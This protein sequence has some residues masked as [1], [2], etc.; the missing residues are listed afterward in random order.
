MTS[1]L[2]LIPSLATR[3]AERV[4]VNL[5]NGL[6][7]SEYRITVQTLFDVGELRSSLSPEVEY[8]RGLPFL[9]RGY[10]QFMKLLP[11]QWLYR[12]IVRQRYD[13]AVAYLEGAATRII[14]G[15]P[16]SDSKK[17]AWVHTDDTALTS[18]AYCYRSVAEA[19]QSYARFD[20]VVAVS[21]LI[22]QHLSSLLSR[23]CDVLYNVIDTEQILRL[24]HPVPHIQAYSTT[25]NVVSVGCLSSVK[26]YD[27]LI[28]AHQQLL[29]AGIA[30]HLYLIGTGPQESSLRQLVQ[31]LHLQQTV[32]F[33]GFQS[34]PYPFMAQADLYVCSSYNEGFSTSVFEAMALGLPV[35]STSCSGV[36]ELL[37]QDNEY[38]IVV[39]NTDQGLLQGLRQMLTNPGLLQYYSLHSQ[40]SIRR[41]SREQTLQR[42][43]AFFQDI[44]A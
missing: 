13:V 4:L 40:Q 34:N 43:Q 42:H 38:G 7:K 1:L 6:D 27:R 9:L 44:K 20:R 29:L 14:S 5:V 39:P 16:Y 12:L 2:F 26:G 33:L 31:D 10:V 18:F 21:S 23:E 15:C 22:S 3:G 17:V 37:G 41:F 35:V 25:R 24:A 30:H 28:R 8:R 32:H 11:P 36:A 19:K